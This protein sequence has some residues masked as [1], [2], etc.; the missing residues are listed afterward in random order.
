MCGQSTAKR[1]RKQ[2]AKG[3]THIAKL[4]RPIY[5]KADATVAARRLRDLIEKENLMRQRGGG[6]KREKKAK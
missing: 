1:R 5:Y 2:A 4:G 6:K 3:F